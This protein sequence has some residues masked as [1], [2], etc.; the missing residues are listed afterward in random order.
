MPEREETLRATKIIHLAITMGPAIFLGVA[1][2]LVNQ[3]GSEMGADG[4][5]HLRIEDVCLGPGEDDAFHLP[6]A[7]ALRTDGG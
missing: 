7:K 6:V 3:E 1:L 5:H 2:F 4:A